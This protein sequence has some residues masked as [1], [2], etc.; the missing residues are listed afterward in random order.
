M[1]VPARCGPAGPHPF[2]PQLESQDSDKGPRKSVHVY[3]HLFG[4]PLLGSAPYFLDQP[5]HLF[6]A[7]MCVCVCSHH[8]ASVG[9]RR[10]TGVRAPLPFPAPCSSRDSLPAGGC[11]ER[12]CTAP[13]TPIPICSPARLPEPEAKK[14]YQT[15][16]VTTQT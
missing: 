5:S 10:Q 1:E 12:L 9:A 2:Q 3:P 15:Y 16:K 7:S 14:L 6:Q 8:T 11:L 13:V 4:L